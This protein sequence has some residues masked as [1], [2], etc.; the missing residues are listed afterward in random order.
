MLEVPPLSVTERRQIAA[1][2]LAAGAKQLDDANLSALVAAPATGNPRFL[3]TVLDELR[4]HGD[5][6]TLRERIDALT[7]APSTAGRLRSRR[8]GSV[9]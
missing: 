2:V 6:F 9:S 8:E 4:Q 7:A 3:T 5:H 1:T